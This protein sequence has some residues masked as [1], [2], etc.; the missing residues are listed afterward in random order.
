MDTPGFGDAINNDETYRQLCDVIDSR[1]E[2]YQ[3]KEL[4]KEK[5]E[6]SGGKDGA[7]AEDGRIHC[8]L[9]FIRPG[10]EGLRSLDIQ[11]LQGLQVGFVFA[12]F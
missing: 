4:R 6:E 1:F 8:C 2:E 10:C 3:R 12:G 9:Y 7:E 5:L 11:V